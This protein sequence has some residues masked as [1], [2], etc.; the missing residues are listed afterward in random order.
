MG[1]GAWNGGSHNVM[2]V[3]GGVALGAGSVEGMIGGGEALAVGD[4]VAAKGVQPLKEKASAPA[5]RAQCR[6]D[7]ARI[8]HLV[9]GGQWSVKNDDGSLEIGDRSESIG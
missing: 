7:M 1:S 8:I 3:G 4:P 5:R 6:N 9:V 2:T